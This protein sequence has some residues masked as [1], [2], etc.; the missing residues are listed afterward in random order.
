[1]VR[2]LADELLIDV[3]SDE[4]DEHPFPYNWGM[5]GVR[6]DPEPSYNAGYGGGYEGMRAYREAA[7]KAA[8]QKGEELAKDCKCQCNKIRVEYY[9]QR[10]AEGGAASM[11]EDRECDTTLGVFE[12]EKN[13]KDR[14]R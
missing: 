10:K 8:L 11:R 7:K 9:C 12:C 6:K 2:Y 1:M 5:Y 13:R 4:L 3:Q 14:R